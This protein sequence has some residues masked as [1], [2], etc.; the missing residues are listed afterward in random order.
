MGGWCSVNGP[1]NWMDENEAAFDCNK[2]LTADLYICGGQPDL[3]CTVFR[4]CPQ[5]S[6]GFKGDENNSN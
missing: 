5:P 4:K 6:S 2:P 3:H 1:D